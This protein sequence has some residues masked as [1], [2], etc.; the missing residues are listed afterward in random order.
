MVQRC[1]R[2]IVKRGRR[3]GNYRL[4]GLGNRRPAWV[5]DTELLQSACGWITRCLAGLLPSGRELLGVAG[6]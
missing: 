3:R 4:E 2:P 5:R 1:D 6:K